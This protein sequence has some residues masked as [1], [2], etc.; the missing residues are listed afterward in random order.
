MSAVSSPMPS[1][2]WPGV[3]VERSLQRK[4]C[5]D[6]TLMKEFVLSE[7]VTPDL[8]DYLRNFG[9]MEIL[10][11]QWKAVPLL[12][13]DTLH[14]REGSHRGGYRRGAVFTRGP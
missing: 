2:R 11:A 7:P 12:R 4:V 10:A 1:R 6:G 3:R 5:V 8:S 13:K 9:D 14:L